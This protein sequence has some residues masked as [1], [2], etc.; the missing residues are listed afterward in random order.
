[1]AVGVL[2]V[3]VWV[4]AVSVGCGCGLCVWGVGVGVAV[5]VGCGCVCG[6]WVCKKTE[7]MVHSFTTPREHTAVSR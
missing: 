2:W 6:L 5:G 4:W 3:R 7:F 1:M